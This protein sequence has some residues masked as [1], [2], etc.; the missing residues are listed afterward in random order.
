[1]KTAFFPAK[2]L[3]CLPAD[4]VEALAALC[5]EFERFD[6]HARELP[7]HHN[8]YVEAL[9][10]LR[11]FS[12]ARDARLTSFPEIGSQQRQNITLIKSYFSLL[13]DT[14]RA[15][16]TSRHAKGYLESKTE[17]YLSL[18]TKAPGYEFS[19]P[20]LERLQQLVTELRDLLRSSSLVP[21]EQKRRLLRKLEATQGEFHLKTS[22]LDRFW[23]FLGEAAIAMRKFGLD[24]APVSER[25]LELGTLVLGSLFRKEGIR[26]LPEL[27]RLLNPLESP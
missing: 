8:D 6:G 20:D 4:N 19:P 9:S 17:E 16:L 24:L 25:V 22:D 11:A 7:E 13:R 10:I 2:T 27:N 15:E 26:A 23:G 1:M 12:A 21:D 18:F 3:A 5:V 14:V